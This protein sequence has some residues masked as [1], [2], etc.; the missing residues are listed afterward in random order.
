MGADPRSFQLRTQDL[1]KNFANVAQRCDISPWGI[2][3]TLAG[4]HIVVWLC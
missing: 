4:P 3:Y 1:S 2:L